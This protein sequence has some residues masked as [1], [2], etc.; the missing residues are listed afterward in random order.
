[1][2]LARRRPLGGQEHDLRSAQRQRAPQLGKAHLVADEKA[3]A[4]AIQREG[5]EVVA[6]GVDLVLAHR[7]EG[8]GLVVFGNARARAVKDAGG[9]VDFAAASV[10][11]A[12][13]DDVDVQLARERGKTSAHGFCVFI[14]RRGKVARGHEARV[15]RLGQDDNVGAVFR[16]SAAH[17]RLRAVKVRFALQRAH[18]HLDHAD[19]HGGVL[20]NRFDTVII[21]KESLHCNAQQ[22]ED[23]K[24]SVVVKQ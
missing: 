6:G 14:A 18:I 23:G 22:K 9:V 4:H 12:S 2:V 11:H 17:E 7:R 19:L 3:A 8:V 16:D 21:R 15:P 20:Q 1:M 10:R 13:R 5:D 24:C